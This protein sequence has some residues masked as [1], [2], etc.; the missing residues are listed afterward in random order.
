VSRKQR[1]RTDR[2]TVA[3]LHPGKY[4]ANFAESLKDLLFHD[5]AAKQRIVSH[6]HGQLGKQC[7][8]GGIVDG[9]NK[10]VAAFLDETD[11]DWLFWVDSDMGFAPD[12]VDRLLEAADPKER[13]IVGG[14]CFAA[15][16]TGAS[17]FHGIRYGT[18]PTLYDFV[19]KGVEGKVGF[20]ARLVYPD[21]EIV[22]V[23]G[24]GSA[25]ILIARHVLVDIRDKYGDNWYTPITH[26]TGPTTFSEDLS[27]CVRAAACDHQTF[28]H[29][30]VKTC[31]DKGFVFLDEEYFVMQEIAAGRRSAP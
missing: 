2:V 25:C 7:S 16:T 21:N 5:V 6:P 1:R 24:T 13:P 30:G 31:H 22:P 11:I 26:P 18:C 20:T 23:A 27:F 3:F 4:N 9:R 19:D 29:T 12:T 28:V 14:L 8:S 17:S 10:V 15:M